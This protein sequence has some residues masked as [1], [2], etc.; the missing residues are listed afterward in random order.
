MEKVYVQYGCGLS[1]PIEWMNYDISPT[2]RL[3]RLPLVG[4]LLRRM[5]ETK[6]PLNVKYGNIVAGL[7][8]QDDKCDGI[9][10]SHT[11]EHLSLNDLRVA[12]K[13]TYKILKPGGIF[14]CVLP[15]LQYA[16]K[17]YLINLESGKG[18]S[19]ID[20][21][22]STSLGEAS[23]QRGIKSLLSYLYGNSKHLW[24]WDYMSLSE[25]LRKIGFLDIRL[26]SFNDCEDEMFKLVENKERFNNA[27]ALEC[28]K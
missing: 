2:L 10:C 23:R 4:N 6:F 11:L 26:C 25:E 3:Q 27:L 17:S 15:D 8:V 7:P 20:F 21:M 19:S 22:L 9:Y 18:D 24:M 28:K 13:N 14:R 16:A 12:L 1:A 5:M